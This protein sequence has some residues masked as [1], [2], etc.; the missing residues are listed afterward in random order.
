MID[1][2]VFTGN[3]LPLPRRIGTKI[4]INKRHKFKCG[5]HII[6]DMIGEIYRQDAPSGQVIHP[7]LAVIG[8]IG[9]DVPVTALDFIEEEIL[10]RRGATVILK[11][12]FTATFEV[13][14]P[15]RVM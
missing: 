8:H 14:V 3:D 13:S 2:G 10:N 1:G 7:D 4:R 5:V 12:V 15:V 6:S 9:K 11:V